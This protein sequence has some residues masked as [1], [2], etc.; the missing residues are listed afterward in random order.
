MAPQYSRQYV[1][2]LVPSSGFWIVFFLIA[3]SVVDSVVSV[4]SRIRIRNTNTLKL[5]GYDSSLMGS[6]NVMPSYYNYF[7]LSTATKSLNT[8]ISYTGGAVAA[9]PAGFLVDWRGRRESIFWSCIVT[10]IGAILQ[11]SAVHIAMFIVG[12]FVIGVGMAVAAT[13][14]PTFVA[15]TAPPKHR[16]FALGLYYSCWGVGTLIASGVCYRVSSTPVVEARSLTFGTESIRYQHL[17]LANPK[18]DPGR[19]QPGMLGSPSL[20]P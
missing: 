10:L 16:A 14:T 2:R 1:S 17:G 7:A 4:H 20:R 6:L 15:E 9:F 19:T 11:T 3:T 8:A 5:L 13:A 18:R 12:R